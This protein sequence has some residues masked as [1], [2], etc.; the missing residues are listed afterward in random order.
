[1]KAAMLALILAPTLLS[2]QEAAQG[3]P[4]PGPETKRLGFFIG[5]WT[6][7][8]DFKPG[9]MGRGGKMTSNTNCEWFDGGFHIVCR[10]EG[11]MAGAPMKGMGIMSYNPDTKKYTYYSI[12]NTGMPPDPAYGTVT[13][14]T[15][16]WEG[17]GMMGGQMVKGRYTVR[18][19]SPDEHTW[20]W[21][22][23]AAGQPLALVAEGTA[24]RVKA[25]P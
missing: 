14:D 19:V 6:S 7:A 24:R 18:I 17:E 9:P 4:Q 21:E 5:R 11:S 13:G 16:T 20:K 8:G 23:G 1:M 22:M 10:Y 2:A 15:W 25:M 12:D 3:P